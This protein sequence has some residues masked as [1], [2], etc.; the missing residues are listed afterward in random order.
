MHVLEMFP[1]ATNH[2]RPNG[3]CAKLILGA[4]IEC[5]AFMSAINQLSGEGAAR[6]AGDL[7]A[8]E[9]EAGPNHFRGHDSDWRM[10]TISAA[11]RLADLMDATCSTQK[12]C[13]R[14]GERERLCKEQEK[15]QPDVRSSNFRPLS[16]ARREE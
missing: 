13:Y 2:M 14:G 7:W 5:G 16:R 1:V 3:P 4:E 12:T 15:N 11:N 6:T 9:L 8:E 10:V